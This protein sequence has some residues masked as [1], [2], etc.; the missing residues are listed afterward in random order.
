MQSYPF[1]SQV[2]Y[3]EQGLPLY[4][5]AVDSEFLRS[6]F[7]A[8]F[9]DGIF[10][11]PTNALQ[12]VAGTGM[13]VQVNP[14]TCHI[15]GAM[16]IETDTRTLAVEAAGTLPRIDTVVARLDLSL[17]VRS[18]ELYI[19][20]GTPSSTPQRPA[21]TRDA[22]I[23][24]LGLADIAVA[25]N[26]STITQ[27]SIT[28]T[29]L[30]T[31]RCGVVAQTIG[32]LDTAPYFAQLTT[33]I[34]E[35]QE[36]AETQIAALQAAIAAVEGDTAW[37][38]KAVYDPHN[39]GTDVYD[40]ADDTAET[41]ANA[42]AAKYEA[43]LTLDGW[44]ASTSEEQS[45]GYPYAQEATLTALTPGAPTVM[46]SSEFLSPCARNPVGVPETDAVLDEAMAIIN[47]Q[48]VTSSLDGG[49][50]R[51]IIQ[52]KPTADVALQWLIRTEV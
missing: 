45:A 9:S 11:K 34:A 47:S 5:R 8:Y 25:A 48:G 19:L 41:H 3:D 6:V 52:E 37:M 32:S 50:I 24:E 16:G 30:D 46:E 43:T 14:G 42:V 38:M 4:D 17:A 40:Y 29:R 49:K 13:Q 33:A 28:D 36:E 35:H 10:Y 39:K 12:V 27:S 21:L 18:I 22:T 2:T 44:V 51:T 1:T 23:W 31:E 7:A 26:A 15:R 20:K